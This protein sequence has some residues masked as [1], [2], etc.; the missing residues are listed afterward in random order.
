MPAKLEPEARRAAELA[1]YRRYNAKRKL[2]R[3]P[4][5][6][7]DG[8]SRIP[9]PPEFLK[10]FSGYS[11]CPGSGLLYGIR[12][13]PITAKD[14]DGYI[15]AIGYRGQVRG[16]AHRIVWQVL[17]GPIPQ[18]MVIN[19]KNGIKTDNRIQNLEMVTPNENHQHAIALGLVDN[20]GER[21]PRAKL[22][23]SQVDEIR[24]SDMTPKQLS[25]IY[26]VGAAHIKGIKR[27]ETWK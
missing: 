15:R 14:S 20:R 12:G 19:H 25:E 26:G 21:S 17:H 18:D 23:Q 11:V 6:L 4:Q 24:A 16:Y 3:I 5:P 22:T 13:F 27:Y 8:V 9:V 2:P 10:G 7:V 1:K